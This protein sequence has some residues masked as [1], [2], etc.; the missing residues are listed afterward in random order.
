MASR[1]DL[2]AMT[3]RERFKLLHKERRADCKVFAGKLNHHLLQ[4]DDLRM[5][6]AAYNIDVR[7]LCQVLRGQLSFRNEGAVFYEK[8]IQSLVSDAFLIHVNVKDPDTYN[9]LV[10][11]IDGALVVY[12]SQEEISETLQN[13]FKHF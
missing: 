4:V 13:Y 7:T 10:K 5:L 12:E 11:L 3:Q 1:A 8:I 9:D 2:L 6:E